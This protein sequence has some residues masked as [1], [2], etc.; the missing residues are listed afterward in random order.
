MILAEKI[1]KLRKQNGWS[2]EELAV[3]MNV[4]RQSVSKWE[5]MSSIPDLDKIIK[6]SQ[7]FG[8]T[9][10]YL[11][12]DELDED[13]ALEP[14]VD[15][16]DDEH[17]KVHITLDEANKYMELMADA[18]KKIAVGVAACILSPVILI[19]LGG[20]E[21]TGVLHISENAA[22]GIGVSIL[23]VIVACAV[24]VFITTGM[25]LN[26]YEFM[27]KELLDLEYGVT[28][29]VETKKENY[30]GIHKTSI[31]MGVGLCIA[32]VIPLFIAV[33]FTEN[34]SVLITTVG[35]LLVIVAAGVYL[36]V[37]SGIVNSS[38][39]KLLEEGEYTIEK[40]IVNKKNSNLSTIYWCIVVAIYLGWSFLTMDWDTTWII[41]P[42]AGVLFG[43][44][45]ALASAWENRKRSQ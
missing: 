40:K 38:Y 18:S 27:D 6:L 8:V 26:Q 3:Q 34:E 17:K 13:V 36:L 10:D 1:I 30:S 44:V 14:I 32:S 22:G 20:Y 21:D 43:A 37:R 12:K 29:I 31:V 45:C 19:L 4:S 11:L 33:A 35:L 41:W 16:P 7:L 28:G 15:Y 2:Q 39:D 25:K 24:M 5:S 23:F 42:V 9:T